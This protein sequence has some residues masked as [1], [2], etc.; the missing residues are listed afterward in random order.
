MVCKLA[1][2]AASLHSRCHA[3]DRSFCCCCGCCL[4]A[5]IPLLLPQLTILL[6]CWDSFATEALRDR[7]PE[8][9]WE[10]PEVLSAGLRIS[11][12]WALCMLLCALAALVSSQP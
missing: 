6:P 12:T 11:V 3:S 9:L 5:A 7:L 1:A 8:G 4:A 10:L 2:L